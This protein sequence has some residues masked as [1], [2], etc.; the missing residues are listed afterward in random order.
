MREFLGA[1][2]LATLTVEIT[3]LP[4]YQIAAGSW[5]LMTNGSYEHNKG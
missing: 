5:F 2:R 4:K 1:T 3:R